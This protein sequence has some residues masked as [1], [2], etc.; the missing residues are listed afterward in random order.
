MTR[1][2][3]EEQTYITINHKQTI[4]W[5]KGNAEVEENLV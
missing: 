3:H 4:E 2:N 1:R 5:G